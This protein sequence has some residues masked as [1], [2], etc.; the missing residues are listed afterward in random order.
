LDGTYTLQFEGALYEVLVVF[1][2]LRHTPAYSFEPD[3]QR[4]VE[5]WKPLTTQSTGQ[6]CVLHVR[7][8][9]LCGHALPP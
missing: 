1:T 4:P 9:A 5:A 8:S 6:L 2:L 3:G 7:V